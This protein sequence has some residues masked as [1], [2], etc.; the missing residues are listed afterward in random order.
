MH[1]FHALEG[2]KY[3]NEGAVLEVDQEA[4][5]RIRYASQEW[6]DLFQLSKEEILGRTLMIL[7]GPATNLPQL[8]Q[9]ITTAAQ[10]CLHFLSM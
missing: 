3:L 2:E 6:L 1:D 9:V 4:P 5:H 10:V 7:S 8:K